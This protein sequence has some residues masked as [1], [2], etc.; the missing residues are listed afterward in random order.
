MLAI[1][2]Y[3]AIVVGAAYITWAKDWKEGINIK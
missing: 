1:I 3:I 2:F